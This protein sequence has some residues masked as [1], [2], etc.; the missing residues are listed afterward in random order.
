MTNNISWNNI[1]IY[2]ETCNAEE[3]AKVS[4]CVAVGIKCILAKKGLQQGYVAKCS[5]FSDQQFSDMVNGRKIIRAEYLPAI[6]NAL[7]VDVNELFQA[8]KDGAS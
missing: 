7:G 1:T 4:S 3:V 2:Q 6:A 8:G 5:G